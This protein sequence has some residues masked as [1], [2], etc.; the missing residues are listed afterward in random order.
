MLF[1]RERRGCALFVFGEAR[2]NLPVRGAEVWMLHVRRFDDAFEAEN[3]LSKLIRCH[4]DR[5]I[6]ESEGREAFNLKMLLSLPFS[7]KGDAGLLFLTGNHDEFVAAE[8]GFA[9]GHAERLVALRADL[10][11]FLLQR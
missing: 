3:D 9:D 4:A 1:R 5:R 2:E 10:V 6:R 7:C 11:G 8:G